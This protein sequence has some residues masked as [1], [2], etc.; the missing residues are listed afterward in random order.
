MLRHCDI[1]ALQREQSTRAAAR[2]LV[3]PGQRQGL[4]CDVSVRRCS[5]WERP[6]KGY[7]DDIPAA[8]RPGSQ[9]TTSI[10]G[11][12]RNDVC[13]PLFSCGENQYSMTLR[14]YHRTPQSRSFRRG[15][16]PVYDL[17]TR[18]AKSKDLRPVELEMP[19][20]EKEHRK[21]HRCPQHRHD[22]CC[23]KIRT[24]IDLLIHGRVRAARETATT[25]WRSG[26][27][28]L[29][30]NEWIKGDVQGNDG[31]KK[32]TRRVSLVARMVMSKLTD[33]EVGTRWE[34]TRLE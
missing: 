4:A 10:S 33:A 25:A 6:S 3:C 20:E 34:P 19:V 14:P 15:T 9:P 12:I 8:S 28:G 24:P 26:H 27:L 7:L 21:K 23:N 2:D 30:G 31:R 18:D 16:M 32:S 1:A 13:S 5:I 29:D 22:S 17:R 11:H